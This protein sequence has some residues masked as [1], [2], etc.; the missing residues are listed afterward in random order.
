[1]EVETPQNWENLSHGE[2]LHLLRS[3]DV[4]ELETLWKKADETREKNVGNEVHLRG[5][6]EVSNICTGQCTYCGI[7]VRN[8]NVQRYR[9]TLEEILES[10]FLAEKLGYGSVVLQA[11]EAPA[12]MPTE[13]IT[14]IIQ[15]IRKVSKIAITLSLGERADNNF[16]AYREWFSAGANRYLLRFETSN[17]EL[18]QRLHPG[19]PGLN[20]RLEALRA[21]REI[22]YEVG[23]GVM[24]GV[25]G[26]TWDDLA[27]DI[28][29]FRTLNL[30]MIGVGPYLPHPE[31]PLGQEYYQLQQL[32]VMEPVFESQNANF[33]TNDELMTL[34][35]VALTRLLCPRSNIPATTAL[36]CIDRSQGH[37]NGLTRGANVIMPNV[38]PAK[39]RQLYEI[40]PSKANTAE[41]AEKYDRELKERILGIGREIGKGPGNS[42][43]H[44]SFGG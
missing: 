33:V 8:A 3:L 39:Y 21:L 22:G 5:L 6:I 4:D 29:M 14:E 7:R 15:E 2:I 13:W 37:R 43:V 23:S 36:A 19:H 1:M 30:D 38:T 28:E 24:V 35:T 40:Y 34:K 42:R 11:G 9:M 25:P 12:A 10:V 20:V 16:Q 31:T 44:L 26:Q 17:P 18:F 32:R 41:E 27:N